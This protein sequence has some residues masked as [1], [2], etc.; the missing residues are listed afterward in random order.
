ML[1]IAVHICKNHP[2]L[3]AIHHPTSVTTIFIMNNETAVNCEIMKRD[4]KIHKLSPYAYIYKRLKT[5]E[6][7]ERDLFK[8][9]LLTI[10]ICQNA[11]QIRKLNCR[12]RRWARICRVTSRSAL[13]S[14]SGV[15]SV[16]STVIK[17]THTG[18]STHSHN[19]WFSPLNLSKYFLHFDSKVLVSMFSL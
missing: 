7:R 2:C 9:A 18:N 14:S 16:P 11:L 4:P 19:F 5:L 10:H 17:L 15:Q 3:V 6:R 12:A 8:L 13:I 1:T